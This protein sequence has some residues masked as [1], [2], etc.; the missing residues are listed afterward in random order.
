MRAEVKRNL[1]LI[2]LVCIS[3]AFGQ[4]RQEE[5]FS[6]GFNLG[7]GF[8]R[9]PQEKFQ[10]PFA[11]AGGL[12]LQ[13]RINWHYMVRLS[14]SGLKTY[15]YGKIHGQQENLKFNTTGLSLDVMKKLRGMWDEEF[16]FLA[17]CGRDWIDQKIPG[18]PDEMKSTS[19]RLGLVNMYHFEQFS[20]AVE[21]G[22]KVFILDTEDPQVLIITLGFLF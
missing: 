6:Y 14:A 3:N 1:F 17:G 7:I 2:W 11:L 13:Y 21:M 16:F 4:T 8:P 15:Q 20:M 5:K 10:S 22:W 18:V 9:I 19:L 12:N